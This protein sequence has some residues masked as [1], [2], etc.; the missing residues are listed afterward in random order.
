M[1]DYSSK[2]AA[3]AIFSCP[4]HLILLP[5]DPLLVFGLVSY[6]FLFP[7]LSLVPCLFWQAVA[8]PTE[9]PHNPMVNAGAIVINS[10][11]KVKAHPMCLTTS[12]DWPIA[13]VSA[14]HGR[15]VRCPPVLCCRGCVISGIQGASNNTTLKLANRRVTDCDVNISC[16]SPHPSYPV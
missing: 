9:K 5:A 3:T 13:S 7:N 6:W 4:T 12:S 11:I 10:L 16:I 2:I 8:H 15:S 1:I 14:S